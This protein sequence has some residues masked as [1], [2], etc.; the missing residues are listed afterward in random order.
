ME[1]KEDK[2]DL[3]TDFFCLVKKKKFIN[4]RIVVILY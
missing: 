1:N 3:K 2:I 4:D